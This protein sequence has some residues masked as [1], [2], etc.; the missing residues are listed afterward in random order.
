MNALGA[1]DRAGLRCSFMLG[2]R[3]CRLTLSVI[4][5]T[6]TSLTKDVGL[7]FIVLDASAVVF[8]NHLEEGVDEFAFH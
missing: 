2:I 6:S 7:K 5:S 1:G 3:K 8:V 4:D